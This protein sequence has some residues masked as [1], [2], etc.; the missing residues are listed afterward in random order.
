M[1]EKI[2]TWFQINILF[3]LDNVS[4]YYLQTYI[5]FSS[6]WSHT[7]IHSIFHTLMF[8][9]HIK[10]KNTIFSTEE[11]NVIMGSLLREN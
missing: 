10:K 5:I 8:L 9:N 4:Y 2:G 3:L 1:K 11:I 7:T 6:N